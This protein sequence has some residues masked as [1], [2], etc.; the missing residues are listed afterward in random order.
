MHL[1]GMWYA[2]LQQSS[3]SHPPAVRYMIQYYDYDYG[4]IQRTTNLTYILIKA[5]PGQH[6]Y[7]IRVMAV[8][9]LGSNSLWVT[10]EI[11]ES[12]IVIARNCETFPFY[13]FI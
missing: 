4:L 8:N 6:W 10:D 5:A 9:V 7:Y 11:C 13:R 2:F 12:L 3:S 1:V